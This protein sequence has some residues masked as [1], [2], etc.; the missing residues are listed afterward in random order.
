[1]Q[2]RIIMPK[3]PRVPSNKTIADDAGVK[4]HAGMN[5]AET[6]RNLVTLAK[7]AT[8]EFEP[9][10]AVEYVRTAEHIWTSKGL[11]EFSLELRFD[12]HGE[13]GKA[14]ALLGR[15]DE[16]I[17]EYQKIL[18]LC[19]DKEYAPI[20]AETCAQIGQLLCKQGDYDRALGY[21]QRALGTYRRLDDKSGICRSLRNLGVVYVEL[22]EFEEAV[23]TL[24]EATEIA[25]TVGERVLQADLINNLGAVLNMRG[26]RQKA[27]EHYQRSLDMY[28]S[29]NEIR[30]T[31]YTMNNMAITY[32]EE[33]TCCTSDKC[34][35]ISAFMVTTWM[36]G[37]IIKSTVF[38]FKRY[39]SN[40]YSIDRS[41]SMKERS[42]NALTAKV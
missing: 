40:T 9:D 25:E 20:K 41:S 24:E 18:K 14:L 19:H 5:W 23:S 16:A 11:P 34:S 4:E 15:L 30:K 29:E 39:Y 26:E 1:M 28:S 31:A 21:L 7:T 38:K 37:N 17:S 3:N 13:A 22:G 12:V 42:T 6:I 10:K 35:R 32:K 36:H 27:L 2:D 8:S 33:I